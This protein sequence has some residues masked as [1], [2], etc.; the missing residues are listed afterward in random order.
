MTNTITYCLD[1]PIRTLISDW[2]AH[3][4]RFSV[5][6]RIDDDHF[7]ILAYSDNENDYTELYDLAKRENALNIHSFISEEVTAVD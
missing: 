3:I 1:N 7:D 4:D 5:G 6:K 2:M